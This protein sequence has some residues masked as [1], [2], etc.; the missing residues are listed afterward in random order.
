MGKK[1]CGFHG[2]AA[3]CESFIHEFLYKGTRIMCERQ[4]VQVLFAK[5]F[6]LFNP[7]STSFTANVSSYTM[8][9]VVRDVAMPTNHFVSIEQ[10]ESSSLMFG[11]FEFT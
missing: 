4:S 5:C 3:F 7:S 10:R 11:L 9:E 2:I 6:T 1:F 8:G